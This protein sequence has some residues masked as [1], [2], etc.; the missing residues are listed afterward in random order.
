M[1]PDK[2]AMWTVYDHPNDYPHC[3]VAR[4]YE[5]DSKG[6]R[7]TVD[8]MISPNIDALRTALSARGLIPIARNPEDDPKIVETWL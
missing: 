5:I 7:P 4:R 6:A 1:M 8:I 2:L 3:Y